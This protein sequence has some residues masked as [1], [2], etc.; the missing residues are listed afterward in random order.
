MI[1]FG[2]YTKAFR[3]RSAVVSGLVFKH[4]RLLWPL[5]CWL[6]SAQWAVSASE[7]QLYANNK[8]DYIANEDGIR[9]HFCSAELDI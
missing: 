1:K 5:G 7:E 8:S 2:T 9:F 4:S 6:T 3:A